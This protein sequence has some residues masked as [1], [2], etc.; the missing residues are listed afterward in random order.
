MHLPFGKPLRVLETLDLLSEI[1]FVFF[2]SSFE[3]VCVDQLL[4]TTNQITEKVGRKE[5]KQTEWSKRRREG[6]LT[7]TLTLTL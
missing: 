2:V 5:K 3:I 7:L 1:V 4:S 6:M